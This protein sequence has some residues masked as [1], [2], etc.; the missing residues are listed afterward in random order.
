MDA[1]HEHIDYLEN[2]R[3]LF[4]F[5]GSIAQPFCP[6]QPLSFTMSGIIIWYYLNVKRAKKSTFTLYKIPIINKF[7]IFNKKF[8]RLTAKQGETKGVLSKQLYTR[9]VSF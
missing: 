3:L 6:K 9:F 7:C 1:S 4:H 8:L 2:P 5:P